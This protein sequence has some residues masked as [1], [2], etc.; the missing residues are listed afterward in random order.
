MT[1]TRFVHVPYKGSGQALIDLLSG[2]VDLSFPTT[3][4][5]L[6]HVKSGRLRPLGVTSPQRSMLYPELPTIAEAGVPGYSV[7]GW[8]GIFGPAAMPE[9]T[10]K[11]LSSDVMRIVNTPDARER[12]SGGGGEPIGNSPAEFSAFLIQDQQ[13]WMEVIKAANIRPTLEN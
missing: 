1:G 2:H 9:P 11:K 8:Y 7:I 6:P 13:K 12:I 10:L 3:A 5:A 4:A